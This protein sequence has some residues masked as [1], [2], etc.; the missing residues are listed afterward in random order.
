MVRDLLPPS[1]ALQSPPAI[2]VLAL[3]QGHDIR[4]CVLRVAG[5]LPLGGMIGLSKARDHD[6]I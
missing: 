6:I 3:G 1:K 2:P 4:R 5:V